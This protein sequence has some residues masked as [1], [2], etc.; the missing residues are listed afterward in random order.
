MARPYEAQ[1]TEA[2]NQSYARVALVTS[3]F[4]SDLTG[5]MAASARRELIAAGVAEEDILSAVVPGSYELPL[6]ARRLA[7]RTDIAGVLCFGVVIKGETTHDLHVATGAANGIQQVMLETD[8]PVL[9]G[10]LT[11]NTL[12]QARA[13]ALPPEEG[14]EQDKGRECAQALI[15]LLNTLKEL[16]EDQAPKRA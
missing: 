2:L 12:E 4:H 3:R 7:R 1:P 9:L 11:T 16:E 6:V 10:V 8:K 5:A 13:R 15:Q 14:G